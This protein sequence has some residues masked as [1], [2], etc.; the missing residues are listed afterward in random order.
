[1]AANITN[2]GGAEGRYRVLKNLW[3]YGCFSEC[4]RSSK[5]TIFRAYLRDTGTSGL[6]L[7]YQS[8]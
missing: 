2:E 7:H 3:A 5:S 4:F 8:Q 6:P 1:M